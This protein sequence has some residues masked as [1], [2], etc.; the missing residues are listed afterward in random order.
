[1]RYSAKLSAISNRALIEL[2]ACS[3]L[4]V[5]IVADGSRLAA[6]E[7]VR[8][9]AIEPFLPDW[10]CVLAGQQTEIRC[11][12]PRIERNS[13]VRWSVKKGHRRLSQGSIVTRED[14]EF[15]IQLIPPPTDTDV[16]LELEIEF[17]F[18]SKQKPVSK[19]KTIY[20]FPTTPLTSRMETWKEIELSLFDPVGET[21]ALLDSLVVPHRRLHDLASIAQTTK[22]VIVV[23]E[24]LQLARHPHLAQCLAEAV[25]RGV[26]VL[27]LAPADG[28]LSFKSND[29]LQFKRIDCQRESVVQNF[30]PRLDGC[31]W[32]GT[33]AAIRQFQIQQTG[34]DLT[35]ECLDDLD[36]WS[37]IELQIA[38]PTKT[39]SPAKMYICGMGIVANYERG[40]VPRNLFYQMLLALAYQRNH[41]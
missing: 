1:M 36:A 16:V 12:D 19:S 21:H 3:F 27:V 4:F 9:M 30:D 14:A 35:I 23:G 11:S 8:D 26:G 15:V 40:P 22:G 34:K 38:N 33:P 31:L 32:L 6:R 37:W 24:K 17:T 18:E 39:M 29:R 20:V 5:A 10:S 25:A 41:N 28:S 13:S 2:T 7:P